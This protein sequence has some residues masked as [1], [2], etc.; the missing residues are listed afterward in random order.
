MRDEHEGNGNSRLPLLALAKIDPTPPGAGEL[1]GALVR[2]AEA[3]AICDG[4]LGPMSINVHGTFCRVTLEIRPI[5]PAAPAAGLE[6]LPPMAQAILEVLRL[7]GV[8]GTAKALARKTGYAYNSHLRAVLSSLDHKGLV[9][10]TPDGYTL[11]ENY[12]GSEDS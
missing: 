10:R 9:R 4:D 6:C 3:V 12:E 2:L 7:E 1:L 11:G 8:P 5:D